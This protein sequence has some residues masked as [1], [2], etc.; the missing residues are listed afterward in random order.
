M[1][2]FLKLE[3]ICFFRSLFWKNKLV[4]NTIPWNRTFMAKPVL[5]YHRKVIAF[6][7]CLSSETLI[8]EQLTHKSWKSNEV[9]QRTI[10]YREA[11][12]N[13]TKR[14]FSKCVSIYP[15]HISTFCMYCIPKV[16][17]VNQIFKLSFS[18][19]LLF[20]KLLRLWAISCFQPL[21]FG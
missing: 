11:N 12:R 16:G 10:Y 19:D 4:I 9:I 21:L 14:D 5:Y 6:S 13:H 15:L 7:D 3:I 17:L 8:T 20:V 1:P 2:L 18:Q